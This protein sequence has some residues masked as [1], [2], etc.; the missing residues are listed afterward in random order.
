LNEAADVPS[1]DVTHHHNSAQRVFAAYD[2]VAGREFERRQLSKR[3]ST[4][5]WCSHQNVAEFLHL[6][7]EA[8]IQP[9]E[10]GKAALTL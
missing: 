10:Y 2:R 4:A 8:F 6:I 3:D 1:F 7:A 9:N 5:N